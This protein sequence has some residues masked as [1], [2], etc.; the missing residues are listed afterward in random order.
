MSYRIKPEHNYDNYLKSILE[1]IEIYNSHER[2]DI[3]NWLFEG[4]KRAEGI[5]KK[6]A[7]RK[8]IFLEIISKWI[9]LFEDL[10]IVCLMFAGGTIK[11]KGQSLADTNKLPYEIYATDVKNINILKF[12]QLA[13]KGFSKSVIAKIYAY[14]TPQELLKEGAI[15]PK[16]YPYFKQKIDELVIDARNNFNKVARAY[17]KRKSR[18]DTGYGNLVKTYF[19][20]KHGFKVL[21]NTPTTKALWNPN[22]SDIVLVKGVSKMRSGRKIMRTSLYEELKN[23]DVGLLL[24]QMEGWSSVLREIAQAHIEKLDNPNFLVQR[25]RRLKTEEK[26]K[27]GNTKVGRNDPCPCESGLK[28]KRCCGLVS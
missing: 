20:T 2:L 11:Y 18:K 21:H 22:T 17:S 3:A 15:S 25:I 12:Y 16:E 14:K 28:Y 1:A 24:K 6:T 8:A 23:E 13:K 10:A 4:Y 27:S 9:Q 19:I 26:L 7:S 5:P